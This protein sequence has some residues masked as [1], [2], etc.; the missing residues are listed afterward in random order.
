[1]PVLLL[2]KGWKKGWLSSELSVCSTEFNMAFFLPDKLSFSGQ[3]GEDFDKFLCKVE[4]YCVAFGLSEKNEEK[5]AILAGFLDGMAYQKYS[6]LSKEVKNDWK[7]LLPALRAEF[8]ER[9]KTIHRQQFT[10]AIQLEH[11]DFSTFVTCL[12]RLARFGYSDESP[13]MVQMRVK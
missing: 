8:V 9:K 10:E 4:L 13:A 1:M 5:C 6:E 7:S 2:S 3:E 11:Q 12:G